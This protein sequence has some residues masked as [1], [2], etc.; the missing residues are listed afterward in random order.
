MQLKINFSRL[1]QMLFYI[2]SLVFRNYLEIFAKK[3]VLYGEL[4]IRHYG[5]YHGFW[6][7]T[8]PCQERPA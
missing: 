7:F 2:C 4:Q 6:N 3:D 8:F 1:V 5:I